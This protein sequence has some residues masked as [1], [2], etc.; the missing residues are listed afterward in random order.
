LLDWVQEAMTAEEAV[1]GISNQLLAGP[2]V[3][4]DPVASRL[5]AKIR[6]R[7][8]EHLDALTQLFSELKEE[9][10]T[11]QGVAG[12]GIGKTLGFVR[13]TLPGQ[14]LARALRDAYVALNYTAA[15][16]HVLYTHGVLA[17]RAASAGLALRH[18]RGYTPAI[19]E[20]S[21]LLAWAAAHS[22]DGVPPEDTLQEI[23]QALF[24][25]WCADVRL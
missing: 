8:D 22:Q 3:S 5:L 14:D 24:E 15:A 4:E 19:R 12:A 6:E 18:L 1:R 23:V 9:P 17:K 13:R 16:Y 2:P 25:A 10:S 11:V 7:S 20:L 21:H